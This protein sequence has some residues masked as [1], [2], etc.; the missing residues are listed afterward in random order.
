MAPLRR[1]LEAALAGLALLTASGAARNVALAQE[2]PADAR[3][4]LAIMGTIPIY[5]G[6]AADL[7]ELIDGAHRAHWARAALEREWRLVPLDFLSDAALAGQARLLLAQPRGLAPEENVALDKW[8]RAGGLLLLFADPM[9]TG[10]SRFGLG[11]RRRPQDVALLSPIL[12]HWGLVLEFDPEQPAG[13]QMR[14]IAGGRVPVDL[15]GRFARHPEAEEGG[16]AQCTFGGDSVLARCVLEQG[17]IVLLADG[18]MLDLAGPRPGEAE[19]L[20][21]VAALAFGDSGEIAGE[22][23]EPTTSASTKHANLPVQSSPDN[24]P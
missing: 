9:M 17:R 24:G 20:A 13:A 23:V 18:A 11:D 16:I 19:A 15:A 2:T 21:L 5:W 7:G 8:V 4:A 22:G 6:E 12:A 14:E 1:S 3:P 10:E